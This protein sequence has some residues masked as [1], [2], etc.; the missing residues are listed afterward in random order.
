MSCRE[1]KKWKEDC[2]LLDTELREFL[3]K[4]VFL[5][6][7][8]EKCWMPVDMMVNIG[9]SEVLA[10][11][12]WWAEQALPMCVVKHLVLL[13]GSIINVTLLNME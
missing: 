2:G 11:P 7:G 8:K 13:V 3:H 6:G 5:Q 10:T 1:A 9:D 12:V 4:Q